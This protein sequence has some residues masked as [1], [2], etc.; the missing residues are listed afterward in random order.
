MQ[1]TLRH[2]RFNSRSSSGSSRS[3]PCLYLLECA[4]THIERRSKPS[5]GTR[6]TP[7]PRSLA[8]YHQASLWIPKESSPGTPRA[9]DQG[10]YKF[11]VKVVDTKKNSMIEGLS[12]KIS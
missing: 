4:S 2:N 10:K 5:E 7:G 3:Q 6:L 1:T 12:I 11:I 9:T 8:D